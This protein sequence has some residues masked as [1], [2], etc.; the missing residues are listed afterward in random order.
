METIMS[1]TMQRIISEMMTSVEYNNCNQD[2]E[3]IEQ[4]GGYTE[5]DN[6]CTEQDL[7]L[8]KRFIELIGG[9]DRARML[10][11]KVDEC[12]DCLGLIDDENDESVIDKIAAIVPTLPDL[13][14]GVD[15]SM[16]YN[17]NAVTGV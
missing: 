15:L 8:T 10:L 16:L 12:E 17:P 9:I 3:C 13:P 14:S 6:E 7:K 11:D 1:K 5:Q 2:G 4:N